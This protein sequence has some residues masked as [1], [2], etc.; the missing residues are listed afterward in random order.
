MSHVVKTGSGRMR[1]V[2]EEGVLA[3]RD[4]PYA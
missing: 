1:G 3:F 2:Y 4:I